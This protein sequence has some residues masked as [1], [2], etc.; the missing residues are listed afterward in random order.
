MKLSTLI[1]RNKEKGT[2]KADTLLKAKA[3]VKKAGK[4]WTTKVASFFD[5][6]WRK[7][8]KPVVVETKLPKKVSVRTPA[9]VKLSR[10]IINVKVSNETLLKYLKGSKILNLFSGL[11]KQIVNLAGSVTSPVILAL[12]ALGAKASDGCILTV[13][14]KSAAGGDSI[15]LEREPS[16]TTSVWKHIDG[17]GNG[18]LTSKTEGKLISDNK[19]VSL[20][21]EL[22]AGAGN[23]ATEGQP[24]KG[25][26]V[27]YKILQDVKL[28]ISKCFP[29]F[30]GKTVLA[31]GDD[32]SLEEV[33]KFLEDS[34]WTYYGKGKVELDGIQ[35]FEVR[36]SK[37][38]DD[39][40]V[41]VA[42]A[43]RKISY[44]KGTLEQRLQH[45]KQE[46]VQNFD[47][48]EEIEKWLKK[49]PKLA[50]KFF[51]YKSIRLVRQAFTKDMSEAEKSRIQ[52]EYLAT[53]TKVMDAVKNLARDIGVPDK[54][55]DHALFDSVLA[56]GLWNVHAG[57]TAKDL[58]KDEIKDIP[59]KIQD[60]SD[61]SPYK[62]V[63]VRVIPKDYKK[64]K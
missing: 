8:V 17:I 49:N 52:D 62:G 4:K 54:R 1:T 32:V 14:L 22:I 41:F 6:E 13:Q 48:Y 9:P 50:K 56:E 11:E 61:K 27:Q 5:T 25:E 20:I 46:V 15:V 28:D 47:I 58:I 45:A 24:I 39:R 63:T 64:I 12:K 40:T 37:D 18:A 16:T 57:K 2:S 53:K 35:A 36:Y 19:A 59:V 44:I 3:A 43:N 60:P 30:R 21:K 23:K 34:G 42:V 55:V 29:Y 38:F 51:Q 33:Q 10:S 31:A 7:K 26:A